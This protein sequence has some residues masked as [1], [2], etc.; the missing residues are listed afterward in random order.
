MSINLEFNARLSHIEKVKKDLRTQYNS[1]KT[2]LKENSTLELSTKETA[3]R[4]AKAMHDYANEHY[5]EVKLQVEEW[6]KINIIAKQVISNMRSVKN[7]TTK[8]YNICG[9]R[10]D[11]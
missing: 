11:F 8:I 4:H 6:R 2:R 7:Y 10:C 5:L 9:Y 1:L 3:V